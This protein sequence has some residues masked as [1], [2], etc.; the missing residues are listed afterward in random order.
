MVSYNV[1]AIEKFIID[2]VYKLRIKNNLTQDDIATIIGVK[3]PFIASIENPNTRAKYNINHINLLADHFGLSP[4]DF[5][6][7][8]PIL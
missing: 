1:S 6:P 8:K 3:Q 4:R 5:L 2:Y 7:L